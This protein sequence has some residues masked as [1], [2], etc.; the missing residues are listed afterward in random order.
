[1]INTS[2]TVPN[3]PKYSRNLS[4]DVCQLNPPTNNFPGAGS[5]PLLGVLRPEE[6]EW[7][8]F[9]GTKLL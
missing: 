9:M 6:P 8:P 3:I 5:P 4:F 1:M 2:V 7:L